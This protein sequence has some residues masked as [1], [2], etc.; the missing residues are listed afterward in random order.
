MVPPRRMNRMNQLDG[1]RRGVVAV[2]CVLL[3]AGGGRAAADD[4]ESGRA[5]A[6]AVL[7]EDHPEPLLEQ[8]QGQGGGEAVVETRDV[9]SGSSSVKIVPM[10]R[11]NRAVAGWAFRIAERP[12][13]GEFRYLRFAWRADGARGIMLQLHD[14][15]DWNVRYTAGVDEPNWGSKFVAPA[16]PARWTVVT[17]DLYA[18]FG[19]RELHGI[20]LTVFGGAAGFFD[21]IYLGRT[22]D[23]LDRVDATGLDDG[24]APRPSDDELD[25]LWSDLGGEDAARAY[26]AFWTLVHAPRQSI[27]FLRQTLAP[28]GAGDRPDALRR[29]VEDLAAPDQATR[30]AATRRLSLWHDDAAPLLRS[31]LLDP[32]LAAESRRQIDRLLD[33]DSAR[34][35]ADRVRLS[36]QALRFIG[37]PGAKQ[38]VADLSPPG[39]G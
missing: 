25:R 20:A 10:Q 14:Q 39:S 32:D 22:V 1:R 6:T 33:P 2:A 17:R 4:R 28:A 3:L 38:L 13:H 24:T 34:G 30:Q 35:N 9:F 21:H 16:P 15:R 12:R 11:F 26:A 31:A 7:L 8:L 36:L 29:C 23:D 5:G 19:Q 27:P 37:T 18:D